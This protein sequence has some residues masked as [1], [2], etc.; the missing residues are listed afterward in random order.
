MTV[1]L[2][3]FVTA[4]LDWLFLEPV[5]QEWLGAT[6][7]ILDHDYGR[8][9]LESGPCW[10]ARDAAGWVLGAG[11]FQEFGSGYAIAWALMAQ[12]IGRDHMALTRAVRA[13]IAEAPYSRVEALIRDDWPPAR[14][15]AQLLGLR[16][17]FRQHSAELDRFWVWARPQRPTLRIAA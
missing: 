17:V 1:T 2:S 10:T 11:G 9:V 14:R 7:P 8:A 12:G 15:W 5:Q 4:D 3:P 16:P 6:S 13:K